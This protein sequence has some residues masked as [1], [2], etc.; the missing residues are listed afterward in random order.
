MGKIFVTSNLQLG[1]PGAIKK[2]NRAF[3]NV[4]EMTDGLINKWNET[5]TKDDTVWHL[6]NFAHDPKTA[7]DAMIRLNGTINFVLGEHDQ[8]LE[9]LKEKNMLRPGCH[10]MKCIEEC[11]KSTV[12]FSYWPMG[13]W[14]GKTK[15]WFSIIGYP[16]KKF[17][18]DPKNRV[19]NAATDLWGH[20]PQELEKIISIFED[21]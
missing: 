19:I 9:H 5:V 7:Q 1:R 12:A 8:A 18:S 20:K 17:K 15:K 14:P 4:D 13:A 6:G 16:L 11:D 21:F 2:Y 3:S 10:I